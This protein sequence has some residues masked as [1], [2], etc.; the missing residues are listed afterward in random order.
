MNPRNIR[1]PRIPSHPRFIRR[2]NERILPEKLNYMNSVADFISC[3]MRGRG[4]GIDDFIID[5]SQ[6][7][8]DDK[9]HYPNI[10]VPLTAFMDNLVQEE[11]VTFSIENDVT[12]ISSTCFLNPPNPNQLSAYPQVL[13]RVWRFES[14]EDINTLVTAFMND[15]YKQDEFSSHNFLVWLEWCLNEVMDN[16][17]QHSDGAAGFIMGQVHSS[18]KTVAF[19]IA[20]AGRGVFKSFR[21]S[22][23]LWPKNERDALEMAFREGVT[24]DPNV[25]QGNGLW[26]LH[27][28]AEKTNGRLRLGSA[29]SMLQVDENAR[30]LVY[31]YLNAKKGGTVVD[32]TFDYS[33]SV[34]LTDVLG[35]YEPESIKIYNALDES[36]RL[37][38]YPLIKQRSGFGTR[39]SGEKIRHEVS[40]YL[41]SEQIVEVDFRDIN[42]VSSS[43]ADEFIG[44]LYVELGPLRFASMVKLINMNHTISAIVNKAILQRVSQSM[45]SSTSS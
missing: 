25:G 40:N 43:F 5:L 38:R 42:I 13:N 16:V 18:S 20:D 27:E 36:Q 23:I 33:K 8:P 30:F 10:L 3:T 12:N 7:S 37:I 34:D 26:G 35:G 15:I 2:D 14:D 11:G 39:R 4:K 29:G 19:C 17:I 45:T 21:D 1:K 22:S 9:S 28:V 32:F 6:E 41:L 24:R 31:P 44:K